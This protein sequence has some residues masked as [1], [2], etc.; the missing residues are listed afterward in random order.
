M[1]FIE[2]LIKNLYLFQISV[3]RQLNLKS[4]SLF[5]LHLDDQANLENIGCF[6]VNFLCRFI[7]IPVN[8][9]MCKFSLKPRLVVQPHGMMCQPLEMPLKYPLRCIKEMLIMFLTMS[10]AI[11]FLCL[12]GRS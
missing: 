5:F 11:W 7:L 6:R 3:R 8:F 9:F 1:Y 12:Y 2:Y 10:S 4:L